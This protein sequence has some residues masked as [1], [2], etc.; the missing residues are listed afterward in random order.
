[1]KRPT[2]PEAPEMALAE[3]V[4][5]QQG[6]PGAAMLAV[7]AARERAAGR[8]RAPQAVYEESWRAFLARPPQ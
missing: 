4:A 6:G 1:M 8:L 2:D 7:W 3:F 5:R